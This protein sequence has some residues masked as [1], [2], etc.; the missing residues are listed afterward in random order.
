MA[1]EVCC[2]PPAPPTLKPPS[3]EPGTCSTVDQISRACGIAV[4]NELSKLVP[5]LVLLTST[6]GDWPTTCTVSL[7]AATFM[8]WSTVVT[9]ATFTRISWRASEANPARSNFNV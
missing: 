8:T 4:S 1:I 9:T 5:L 6:L 3:V 2:A 7:T